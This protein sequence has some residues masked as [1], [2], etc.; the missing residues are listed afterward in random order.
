MPRIPIPAAFSS[1]TTR[2]TLAVFV[3]SRLPI[4]LL[5]SLFVGF[6]PVSAGLLP[7]F[8]DAFALWDGGWYFSIAQE[9]YAWPGSLMEQSN[10]AFFPLYPFLGKLL[11][12][13]LGG[14]T[15]LGLLLAS[16]LSFAVYLYLLHRLV[17]LDLDNAAALRTVTYVSIFPMSLFFSASYSEATL[18]ALVTGAFYFARTGRWRAAVA[19]G[20]MASLTRMAGLIVVLPLLYEYIRQKGVRPSILSLSLIPASTAAYAAYVWHKTGAPTGLMYITSAWDRAPSPLWE[21]A[22]LAFEGLYQPAKPYD[23]SIIAMDALIFFAF[24]LLTALVVWRL[25]RSYAVYAVPAFLFATSTTVAG[26]PL[27]SM[28]RYLLA[29]FPCFIAMSI[30]GKSRLVHQTLVATFGVFLGIVTIYYFGSFWVE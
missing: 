4:F 30:P 7:H 16:N 8:P 27:A 19:L 3:A 11:G 22:R 2:D 18:L 10:L 15:Q 5:A 9:G 28:S 14:N 13:I 24:L 12:I 20:S 6:V 26:Y 25:P 1:D 23:Y 17:S 21:T 29:V